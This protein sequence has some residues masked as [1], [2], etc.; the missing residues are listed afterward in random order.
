MTS[1]MAVEKMTDG[2]LVR[3][4]RR[5]ASSKTDKQIRTCITRRKNQILGR[6][7]WKEKFAELWRALKTIEEIEE[8]AWNEA[9]DELREENKRLIAELKRR[10]IA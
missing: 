4:C 2:Q 9:R 7:E 1:N 6:P 8:I 5:I 10:N 3:K